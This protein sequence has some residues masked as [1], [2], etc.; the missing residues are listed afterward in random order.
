MPSP[1][2]FAE[3]LLLTRAVT[4]DELGFPWGSCLEACY[5]TLLGVPLDD[6]PDPRQDNCA[7]DA[8]ATE[9]IAA[10]TAALA[11]WLAEAYAMTAVSG[12][13]PHPPG[14]LLRRSEV[15]LFWIAS[16]KSERGLYHA[17]VYSN[18]RLL[19]DPHPSRVGLIKVESW[20]VF[21]P[22][23]PVWDRV[24]PGW[25]VPVGAMVEMGRVQRPKRKKKQKRRPT[26]EAPPPRPRK[27]ST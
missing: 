10:R 22:L 20:T 6:V 12:K 17:T 23:G 4:Q 27:A 11:D 2:E 26:E 18:G 13:G 19:F 24:L 15:P 3:R 16:G 25:V 14:V 5:A 7:T 8:C 1:R 21:V 9:K